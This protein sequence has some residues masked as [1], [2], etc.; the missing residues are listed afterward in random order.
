MKVIIRDTKKD[1]SIWAAHHIAAAIKAVPLLWT[2]MP[3]WPGCA[4]PARFHS[5]T[6]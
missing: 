6:S 4:L 3:S 1:G 5:R 2:Y